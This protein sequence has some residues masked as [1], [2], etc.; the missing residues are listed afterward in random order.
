MIIR[1]SASLFDSL[2]NKLSRSI[3][4]E[5]IECSK[6]SVG[7]RPKQSVGLRPKQSVGLR[8]K[9]SVGLRKKF[10]F[11]MLIKER[12]IQM[13]ELSVDGSKWLLKQF[14]TKV[15]SFFTLKIMVVLSFKT[16]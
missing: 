11:S 12:T 1:N 3:A 16:V 2:T 4:F 13:K 7:L 9:Q 14:K 10:D 6:Q 8:P 5:T 15:S